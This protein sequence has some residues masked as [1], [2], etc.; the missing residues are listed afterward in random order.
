MAVRKD[1]DFKMTLL[2]EDKSSKSLAGIAE[3]SEKLSKIM[4]ILLASF[5]A[6]MGILKTNQAVINKT[7]QSY[8]QAGQSLNSFGGSVQQ[9]NTQVTRM[10]SLL[11]A[12]S[13][14]LIPFTKNI[15]LVNS[16][17]Q[18]FTDK[19]TRDNLNKVLIKSR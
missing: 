3:V 12:T 11:P 10:N 7:T 18:K 5:K 6:Q 2:V 13:A 19:E 9:S 1:Q 4:H 8:T 14:A 17:I 16:G 15:D